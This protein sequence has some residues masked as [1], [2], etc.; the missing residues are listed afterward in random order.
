MAEPFNLSQALNEV[1]LSVQ[2]RAHA[3]AEVF[4]TYRDEITRLGLHGN[5]SLLDSRGENLVMRL[6][7]L[8]EDI[9]TALETAAG[10]TQ[11]D[12]AGRVFPIHQV[13]IYQQVILTRRTLF[14][15]Q[16]QALLVELLPEIDPARLTRVMEMLESSAQIVAPLVS[17]AQVLGVITL[18]SRTGLLPEDVQ[19][20]ESFANHLATA[21]N[22]AR[23]FTALRRQAQ[24]RE[25]LDRVLAALARNLE[26]EAVIHTVVNAI[27]EE[28][29]YTQVSV[30]WLEADQ[31]Q[32]KDQVGYE[33][34]IQQIPITTGITGLV[35][36]TGQPILLEEVATSPEFI[37]AIPGIASEICIPLFEQ[38]QAVGVLNVESV[39]VRLTEADLRLMLALGEHLNLAIERARL[40]AEIR[41]FNLELE[42]RVEERTLQLEAALEELETFSYSVSHDLRAPLRGIQGFSQ[43]ILTREAEHL[44]GESKRWLISSLDSARRMGKLIDALLQFSRLTRLELQKTE[45]DLAPLAQ[46]ILAEL[47]KK[48]P[49]RVV[50]IEIQPNL[51]ALADQ[52]LI[53]IVLEQLLNNAWKF[54]SKTNPASIVV[55]GSLRNGTETF[56]V[57]DNGAGFNMDYAKKLFGPFQ[58]LHREDEFPGEGAGL[59]IVQRILQRHGGR[60]WA[61]ASPGSGATFYFTVH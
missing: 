45:L 42:K 52:R 56:F 39:G 3:E 2:R 33:N 26:L 34:V 27:A 7:F 41:R 14:V 20:I 35:V 61:E 9:K 30:Y 25:L 59:A 44:S 51:R 40:Y 15:P 36:R 24:E 6:T 48:E 60:I 29:G 46:E 16:S 17:E 21:L 18:G 13:Q 55:G 47:Q 32:I 53:S 57:R 28:F 58:R 23:L 4:T 43:M 50:T 49:Q 19:A 8:P 38:G 12:L 31:L 1:A 5:L 11:F 37:C 54:T 22:N 10:V